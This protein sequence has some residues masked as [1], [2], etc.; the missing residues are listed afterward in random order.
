VPERVA[1][2]GEGPV[3][4]PGPISASDMRALYMGVDIH[5]TLGG[6]EHAIRS[7]ESANSSHGEKLQ[8]IVRQT[9]RT[10]FAL[11]ILEKATVLQGEKIQR[12]EKV[13]FVIEVIT[14][15]LAGT[16]A[17]LE[18]INYFGRLLAK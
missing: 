7:L 16:G 4:A 8:Q 11:S 6:M 14:I 12:L 10:D 3:V 17:L 9:D 18:L 5:R 1:S 15:S 2:E 13:V